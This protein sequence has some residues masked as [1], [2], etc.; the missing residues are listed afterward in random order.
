VCVH[1]HFNIYKE[2]GVKLDNK[3]RYGHV[4]KSFETSHEGKET[5][6]WNQQ[7]QTERTIPNN[8]P[9][10]TFRDNK[11]GTCMLIDIAISGDRNVIKIESEMTLICKDLVIE[12]QRM[13]N[14]K[15]KVNNWNHL[16]NH[17]DNT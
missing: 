5:I 12:I 2:I 8:I 4:P 17:S 7:V 3:H 13:W 14:V 6:L 9:D 16:K 1:L 15:A 11:K 10:I